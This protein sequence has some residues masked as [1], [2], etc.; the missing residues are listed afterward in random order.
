MRRPPKTLLLRP[1]PL[2]A[3]PLALKQ[4][5]LPLR[6]LLLRPQQLK[7]LPLLRPT[8]LLLPHLRRLEMPLVSSSY[9][10]IV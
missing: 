3:K 2:R 5:L 4:R 8:L 7:L 1:L 6:P 10:E 9:A